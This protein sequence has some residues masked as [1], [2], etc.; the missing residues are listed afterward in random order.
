VVVRQSEAQFA[1]TVEYS[2]KE[3]KPIM[4]ENIGNMISSNLLEL[5]DSYNITLSST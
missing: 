1:K 2:I 5:I 3:G 4:I